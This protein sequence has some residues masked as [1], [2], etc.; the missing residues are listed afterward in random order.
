MSSLSLKRIFVVGLFFVLLPLPVLAD[1][2]QSEAPQGIRIE[3]VA[4]T[5]LRMKT[6]LVT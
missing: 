5:H 1:S 4:G 6:S 2:P 3:F